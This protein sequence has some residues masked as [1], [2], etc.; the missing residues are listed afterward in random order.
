MTAVKAPFD[1]I[2]HCQTWRWV[3]WLQPADH[4]GDTSAWQVET[5]DLKEVEYYGVT[6]GQN[7][8]VTF[9]AIPGLEIKGVVNRIK[10]YGVTVRGDNT[11]TV[12]VDLQGTDPRVLWNMTA[13]VTFPDTE[14]T[15]ETP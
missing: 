6:A 9:D 12:I 4:V 10:G 8:V 5:I 13:R 7:V 1:G 3:N 15:Q 2:L 14:M 11:Y